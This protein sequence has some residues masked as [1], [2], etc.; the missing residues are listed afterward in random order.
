MTTRG[1]SGPT[2]PSTGGVTCPEKSGESICRGASLV[3]DGWAPPPCEVCCE[4]G[5]G[6]EGSALARLADR[7]GW[8]VVV[9][10]WQLSSGNLSTYRTTVYQHVVFSPRQQCLHKAFQYNDLWTSLGVDVRSYLDCVLWLLTNCRIRAY[11]RFSKGVFIVRNG[12]FPSRPLA[13]ARLGGSSTGVSS[14]PGGRHRAN[15]VR[16]ASNQGRPNGQRPI[17][18]GPG[19]ALYDGRLGSFRR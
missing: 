19:S 3:G 18:P 1:V 15:R 9:I 6:P 16:P 13:K 17:G 4:T 8:A 12:I 14:R 7:P 5:P 11:N 2:P 10:L